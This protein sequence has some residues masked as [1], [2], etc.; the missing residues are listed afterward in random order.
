MLN[1]LKR[2]VPLKKEKRGITEKEMTPAQRRKV[3]EIRQRMKERNKRQLQ[4][5]GLKSSGE[6]EVT[7]N[8]PTE[9]KFEV[10]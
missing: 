4:K 10:R 5:T 6:I 2:K 1:E 9:K 7:E 8:R 3:A